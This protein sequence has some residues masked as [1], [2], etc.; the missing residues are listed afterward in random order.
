MVPTDRTQVRPV[1]ITAGPGIRQ[2]NEW[3]TGDKLTVTR[4]GKTAKIELAVPAAAVRVVEL[5]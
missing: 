4:A 2:A 1:I 3:L 5:Q